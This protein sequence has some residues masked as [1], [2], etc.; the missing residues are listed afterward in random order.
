M[1]PHGC[2]TLL[3]EVAPRRPVLG[4]RQNLSARWQCVGRPGGVVLCDRRWLPGNP[5][6]LCL[7]KLSLLFLLAMHDYVM[8]TLHA[9][10]P[11][12]S[13]GIARTQSIH[14]VHHT[15]LI[16]DQPASVP[17]PLPVLCCPSLCCMP[18]RQ[19][20]HRQASDQTPRDHPSLPRP[21]PSPNSIIPTLAPCCCCW[22]WCLSMVLTHHS[23]PGHAGPGCAAPPAGAAAV[24][25]GDRQHQRALAHGGA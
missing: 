1:K 10:N 21:G 14:S 18:S 25:H 6:T 16:S 8:C 19:S 17:E 4:N 9:C 13:F 3:T 24:G 7:G 5:G 22:A 23:D 12:F 20:C 11:Q 15:Q 2:L